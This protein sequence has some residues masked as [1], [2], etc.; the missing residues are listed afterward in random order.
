MNLVVDKM[1]KCSTHSKH[2]ESGCGKLKVHLNKC[3]VPFEKG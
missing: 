3:F 1:Q 2:C